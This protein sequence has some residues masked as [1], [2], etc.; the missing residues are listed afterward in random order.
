M[1]FDP[2]AILKTPEYLELHDLAITTFRADDALCH[3][4]VSM[5]LDNLQVLFDRG[6][7]IAT[8]RSERGGLGSNVR[9]ADPSKYLQALRTVARG[10]PGTAHCMQV[11][12]HTAWVIDEVGTEIQAERFLKPMTQKMSLSSLVGSEAARKHMYLLGTTAKKVDGGYL[13]N[14]AKNYATNGLEHGIAVIFA[15]IE[16]E[17]DFLKGHLM[18]AIEPGMDGVSVNNDWYRPTGMRV[19]PSPEID[20][21]S[22][23]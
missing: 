19:C 4:D 16:G 7:L 10:S 5:P 13:V 2:S 23:V 18:V 8:V 15:T 3:D 6:L 9:S 1:S 20:R 14:G 22:V 12:N 11:Q 21:K 17:N